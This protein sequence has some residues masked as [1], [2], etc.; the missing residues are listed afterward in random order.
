MQY[1]RGTRPDLKRYFNVTS[2]E[3]FERSIYVKLNQTAKRVSE[4]FDRLQFNT[5]ISALMEL[6]RDFDAGKINN[7]E[8][9]DYIIFKTV[10]MIAPMAPHL[11]EELWEMAGFCESI[12]KCGWPQFDPSA[13]VGDTIEIAVQI[14]GKLRDAVRVPADASQADIEVEA[15]ASAKVRSFTAGKEI[16][17]KIYVPG[18][19]LNIVIKS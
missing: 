13:I 10:Q 14:N 4:G 1:Y 19:L 11:A 18:R 6:V 9:S 16:M 8:L 3:G 15:F 17:K 5:A 12:F 2:L 7:D